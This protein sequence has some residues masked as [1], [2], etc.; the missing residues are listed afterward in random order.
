MN[1]QPPSPPPIIGRS[2]E[3]SLATQQDIQDILDHPK[4]YGTEDDV[5][6]LLT[7]YATTEAMR[8]DAVFGPID[9]ER[10]RQGTLYG[11]S[12]DAAIDTSFRWLSEYGSQGGA[13]WLWHGT[14]LAGNPFELA[15]IS[16][17]T[18]DQNGSITHADV[19]YPYTDEYVREAVYRNGTAP[20]AVDVSRDDVFVFGEDD[21]CE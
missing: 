14:N 6:D 5:V 12:M 7:S 20:S 3:K 10:A 19:V 8:Y 17:D 4:W 15:G 9:M 16:L 11:N 2:D 18:Y 1:W 13:L 21:L